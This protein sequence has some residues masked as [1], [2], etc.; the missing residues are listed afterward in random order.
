MSSLSI[1]ARETSDK[2]SCKSNYSVECGCG[3]CLF[4]IVSDTPRWI[5]PIILSYRCFKSVFFCFYTPRRIVYFSSF[6]CKRLIS[7]DAASLFEFHLTVNCYWFLGRSIRSRQPAPDPY[8][9]HTGSQISMILWHLTLPLTLNY[10]S[11]SKK[12][13][14]PIARLLIA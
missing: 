11:S 12:R 6:Y 5:H 10:A 8:G 14:K 13:G 7:C 1:C 3:F 2:I 9:S 4:R